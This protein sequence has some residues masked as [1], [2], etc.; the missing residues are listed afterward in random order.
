MTPQ[1]FPE[2]LLFCYKRS[3]LERVIG[4][5]VQDAVW[6]AA[7]DDGSRAQSGGRSR[8]F[9]LQHKFCTCS[10]RSKLPNMGLQGDPASDLAALGHASTSLARRRPRQAHTRF[11]AV[12]SAML[13]RASWVRKAECGV[14]STCMSVDRIGSN[15]QSY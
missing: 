9:Y 12:V 3:I 7:I 4:Q 6:F 2:L 11:S 5:D 14:M 8:H 10:Q 15:R 1:P 13:P